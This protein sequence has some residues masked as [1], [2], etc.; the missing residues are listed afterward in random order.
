MR[1]LP[2]FLVFGVAF[3]VGVGAL[4]AWLVRDEDPAPTLDDFNAA[5]SAKIAY[6]ESDPTVGGAD[7]RT[8]E[9]VSETDV[10]LVECTIDRGDGRTERTRWEVTPDGT[11][12]PAGG[13]QASPTGEA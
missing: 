8:T 3:V 12:T 11:A 9:W 4:I 1:N 5:Q 6:V 7:C 2:I 13:G 10:W